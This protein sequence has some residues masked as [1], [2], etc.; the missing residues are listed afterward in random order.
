VRWTTLSAV[1]VTGSQLLQMWLATR[2]V[3]PAELGLFYITLLVLGFLRIFADGGFTFAV[4]HRQTMTALE[5]SSVYWMTVLVGVAIYAGAAA[6]AAPLV[7]LAYGEPRL[8]A[9]V[10]LGALSFVMVPF[11]LLHSTLLR[12]DLRFDLAAKIEVIAAIAGLAA[13]VAA[14]LAGLRLYA[15][16][17]GLFGSNLVRTALF[18]TVGTRGWR[19]G[20][21]LDFRAAAFFV[22][23]G[24]FQVGERVISYLAVRSDQILISAFLG[25]EVLGFYTLAWNFVVDPIYRINPI[26]T[27]VFG[28]V[29]AKVQDEPAR[30]KR[31]FLTLIEIVATINLP[32]VAGMAAV[33]PLLVPL[34]FGARWL[35]IIPIMQIL[36]VVGCCKAIG[37]PT[38]GL[39]LAKGRAD[40][41]FRWSAI[42]ALCQV[43]IL[44]LAVQ[45]GS[46]L[47]VAATIAVLQVATLA[48]LYRLLYRPLIGP[49][50]GAWLEKILVPLGFA[51]IMVAAVVLAGRLLHLTGV[52]GTVLSIALGGAVYLALYAMFRR[53]MVASLATLTF[54]RGSG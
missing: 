28:P 40:L 24:T 13:M 37:N 11:G 33:A 5:L 7:A 48:G 21:R 54:S 29:L 34:M 23:F 14:A 22:R 31:G 51:L 20:L 53:D 46:I 26:I 18:M 3:S 35:P 17:A 10:A 32:L 47:V 38:G 15:L 30:L 49:C 42:A 45:A 52:A 41:S 8:H 36:A 9:L 27:R 1:A 2:M 25:A 44:T 39:I 16:I 6:I 12:K 50:L 19:P 4:F 43:P